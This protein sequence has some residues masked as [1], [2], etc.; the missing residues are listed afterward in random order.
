[1]P[2]DTRQLYLSTS[3]GPLIP[4]DRETSFCRYALMGHGVFVVEDALR[5]PRFARSLLVRQAPHVRFYAGAPVHAPDG[6]RIGVL[7]V[8]DVRP[9]RLTDAAR[10][11]LQDLAGLVEAELLLRRAAERDHLTGLFN[12]R[13]LEEAIAREWRRAVRESPSPLSLLSIDV[14]H[15][16]AYND[17]FGH[18]AGDGALRRVAHVLQRNL[19]RPGDLVGRFGGE[20]FLACLPLT[21]AAGAAAAA[22]SLRAEVEA[23]RLPHPDNAC[24]VVTISVGVATVPDPARSV[25]GEL[26]LLALADA[27]MYRAKEQGRNRVAI[28]NPAGTPDA[29]AVAPSHSWH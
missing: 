14:D 20:E 23:L 7:C 26:H 22:E 19:R 6:T 24:G 29:A 11:A 3:G 8:M 12:R 18:P 10:A 13:Y 28:A 9:R 1:V 25:T 15:F 16:K 17:R 27:A 5:D 4:T 21:D 2:D